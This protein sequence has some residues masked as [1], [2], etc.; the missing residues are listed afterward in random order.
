MAGGKKKSKNARRKKDRAE[1]NTRQDAA[2]VAAD[3]VAVVVV[4]EPAPEPESAPAAA[5][6]AAPT[7]TV[8][9]DAEADG[10]A[11]RGRLSEMVPVRFEAQMLADVK[12]RAAE[13]HRSVSSWIRLAVDHELQRSR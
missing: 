2:P 12:Q 9:V 3:V 7:A 6:A 10:R 11:A 8:A 1:K 5:P 13:D 4:E